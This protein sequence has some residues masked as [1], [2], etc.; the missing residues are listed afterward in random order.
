[1]TARTTYRITRVESQKRNADR[2]NIYLDG[3]FAFGLGRDVLIQHHLHEEDEINDSLIDDVLLTEE[4]A[5]AKEKAI[6]LLAYRARSE[7]EITGRLR[8]KGF[9]DRVV[10]TVVGDLKRAGLVDDRQFASAYVQT[11][12]IQKPVSRRLLMRE[13]A[14]K[15]VDGELAEKAVVE[16]Y[17]DRSELD[18]A[19]DLVRRKLSKNRDKDDRKVK[20]RLCDFLLRRGFAWDVIREALE[21]M[22]DMQDECSTADNAAGDT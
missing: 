10:Q 12:M 5:R 20:K 22:A 6:G 19:R 18:V 14:E 15:G 1:M 3:A 21:M 16:V 7:K 4:R 11:R 17:G 8:E 9:P 13:L 2:V